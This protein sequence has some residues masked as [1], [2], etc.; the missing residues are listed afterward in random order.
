MISNKYT[1]RRLYNKINN[2]L[3]TQS[4]IN[5]NLSVQYFKI[6]EHIEEI[7]AHI[8]KFEGG[9]LNFFDTN[10]TVQDV[11]N[12]RIVV[13]EKAN[14]TRYYESVF[15]EGVKNSKSGKK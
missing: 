2:R 13:L 12:Q 6:I 7:K 15:E 8:T 1:Q 4:V 10:N 9:I 14:K 3:N 5:K 11:L